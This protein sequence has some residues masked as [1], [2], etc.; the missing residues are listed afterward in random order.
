[1]GKMRGEFDFPKGLI[2]KDEFL[3][4]EEEDS[5]VNF[6]DTIDFQPVVMHGQEAKRTVAHFGYNYDF[7]S[8]KLISKGNPFPPLLLN[9]RDKCAAFAEID[10]ESIIMCLVSK[11]PPQ[12]TIGWHT[13]RLIFGSRIIGV[14]LT[15]SCLMRFQRRI[16]SRRMVYEQEL[17]PRSAYILSGHARYYWQHSIP[18]TKGLRYSITF[19]TLKK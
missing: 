17:Q 2:Y 15:S 8:G 3:T 12:S 6:I 19:R 9:L 16:D 11:Y 13:D 7:E 10:P 14:S 4:A 18:P 1:M 5:L